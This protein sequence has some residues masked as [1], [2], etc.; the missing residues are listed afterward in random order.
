MGSDRPIGDSRSGSS[1]RNSTLDVRELLNYR[2][3]FNL[4]SEYLGS[5]GPITEVLIRDIHRRL[6]E[7]VRGDEGHPGH[8]GQFYRAIQNVR[9]Q[10]LDLT[11]WLEF[12]VEGLAT[13]LGEVK[14]RGELVIRR[15]V[16]VREH[17]L[18][19]RQAEAIGLLLEQP[20]MALEDLEKLCPAVNP[21]PCSA[22]FEGSSNGGS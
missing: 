10:G 7:G 5:G 1:S 8:R 4:V 19:P 11:G 3:A 17:G 22:T 16:I 9:E 18:N 21:R 15:D 14:A 2:D 6:V 13:Q 12:F 20:E